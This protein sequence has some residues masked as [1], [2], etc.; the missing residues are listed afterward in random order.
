MSQRGTEYVAM[1]L[2]FFIFNA[3]TFTTMVVNSKRKKKK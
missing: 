2:L 1:G 3:V